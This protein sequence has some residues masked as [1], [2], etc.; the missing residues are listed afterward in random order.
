M[1][2]QTES[3]IHV[4][5]STREFPSKR[6]TLYKVDR[7]STMRR[8]LQSSRRTFLFSTH[9]YGVICVSAMFYRLTL[10]LLSLYNGNW[11]PPDDPECFVSGASINFT[12]VWL[13]THSYPIAHQSNLQSDLKCPLARRY[14]LTLCIR[15]GRNYI[16]TLRRCMP[17]Q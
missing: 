9:L 12:E 14:T 3:Y 4:Y 6:F 8:K 7:S 15:D 16:V 13:C 10:K 2:T 1:S 11:D 17:A 5:Y